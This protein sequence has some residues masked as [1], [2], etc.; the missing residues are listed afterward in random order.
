MS[1][2]WR[3]AASRMLPAVLLAMLLPVGLC[4]L[5]PAALANTTAAPEIRQAQDLLLVPPAPDAGTIAVPGTGAETPA[6]GVPSG[7]LRLALLLPLRSPA[8][9]SAAEMV[10]DGFQ[11]AHVRDGANIDLDV[12]DTDDVPRHIVDAYRD[13]VGRYDILVGPLS[14]SGVSALAASGSVT[15]PTI[16]LAQ[17]DNPADNDTA[18]PP[19]MLVMGLSIEEEARQ[20]ADWAA[21][22]HGGGDALVV[23]TA[24]AWQKRAA[25]AFAGQWQRNGGSA[26]VAELGG[27]GSGFLGAGGLADLKKRLLTTPPAVIF[28]ALDA[29][30]TRQLRAAIGTDI[31]LYGTSQLNPLSLAEAAGAE[32]HPELD[33]VRL[34]DLP[35]QLQPD[36]PAVMIYPHPVASGEVRLGPDLERLYALGI[37]AFRVAAE[38]GAGRPAFTIDGVTG[39]L[40]VEF[41]GRSAARFERIE[42]QAVYREGVVTPADDGQRAA[43]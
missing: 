4:G 42:P 5:C 23:A 13:A 24:A 16:V 25:R 31:E 2:K 32:A 21:R 37:D 14:R 8:L 17:P 12:I 41:D 33:G 35:W 27:G 38:I 1:E 18:L 6:P 40:A 29:A 34:L 28:V 9:K 26:Q 19:D 43:Q 30:Q 39:R 7:R 22:S 3:R 10:R 36:H 20:A 11:A 15:R